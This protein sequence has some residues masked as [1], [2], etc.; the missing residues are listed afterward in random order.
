MYILYDFRVFSV[1]IFGSSVHFLFHGFHAFPVSS[2]GVTS[3][4]QALGLRMAYCCICT[5]MH[6]TY[7]Y[8]LY[9]IHCI[10]YECILYS[11]YI[12]YD[13]RYQK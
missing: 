6:M 9:M 5:G 7:A 13:C 1:N 11:T 4:P 2:I 10:M 8:I 12:Y 3:L